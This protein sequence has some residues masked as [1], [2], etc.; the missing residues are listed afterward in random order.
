MES[1]SKST[2]NFSAKDEKENSWENKTSGNKEP[3]WY[4]NV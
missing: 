3:V 4:A 1:K 2:K